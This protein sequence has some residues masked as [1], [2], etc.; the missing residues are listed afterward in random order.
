MSSLVAYTNALSW[1]STWVPGTV[2]T[3]WSKGLANGCFYRSPLKVWRQAGWSFPA[4]ALASFDERL[5]LDLEARGVSLTDAE[6]AFYC[7]EPDFDALKTTAAGRNLWDAMH[8]GLL[9]ILEEIDERGSS[10]A[11][12]TMLR[13]LASYYVNGKA[14][15]LRDGGSGAVKYSTQGRLRIAGWILLSL[16]S[17]I[18]AAKFHGLS[19]VATMAGELAK[20]HL[21]WIRESWPLLAAPDGANG[22]H[23][24]TW[25]VETFM[26]GILGESLRQLAELG[27]G[28]FDLRKQVYD[29]TLKACT[30]S[31]GFPEYV[32][33]L[34]L[35]ET[36]ENIEQPVGATLVTG[37]GGTNSW[38]SGSLSLYADGPHYLALL[39][40]ARSK[41]A[42]EK[43]SA[44]F[45][46]L[47]GIIE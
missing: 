13:L 4:S 28:V 14:T 18:R 40:A 23:V 16:A 29:L 11:F 22:D 26:L 6:G 3:T 25:H 17:V 2:T 37:W 47:F 46:N 39:A 9:P 44:A 20:Q 7:L 15:Y 45:A 33:D 32:Y 41:G 42:P 38:L 31:V 8:F 43:Y 34:A 21:A 36:G 19:D 30:S 12:P 10:W 1:L 5:R 27:F 24:N 35:T